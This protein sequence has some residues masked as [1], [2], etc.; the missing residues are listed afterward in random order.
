MLSSDPGGLTV[1]AK[2]VCYAGHTFSKPLDRVDLRMP[3]DG[4]L[5]S[6]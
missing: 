6:P 5:D 2:V 4:L 1:L 3:V